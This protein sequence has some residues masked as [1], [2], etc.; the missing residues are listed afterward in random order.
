MMLS[1][2]IILLVCLA[3]VALLFAVAWFAD[4][5]SKSGRA[6]IFQ[7][8]LIY[9]LSISVYC[10]SWTF[11]GAVGSAARNGLEF[12][13]IYLGPTIVFIGFWFLLRKLVRIGRVHRIT[14]IADLISSRYGKGESLAVLV[15][16]IAVI[17]TTPYIALQLKAL[18]TSLQVITNAGA[19]NPITG[20]LD[21]P[22][23]STAFWIAA[24]MA[25]FTIM[26]G[27]R[28]IDSNE[29]HHGV[30]AAIAIEALVKLFALL[31]VGL[32]V[33]FYLADGPAEVFEWAPPDLLKTEEVF[34][35]RWVAVTFLAAVAII[36]LPR[37]FQVTVVENSDERHIF[38]ASWMFPLYL[39]LISLFVLPIAI[40]GLTFLPEGADPD[41]FVLT[42]PLAQDQSFLALIAFL[43]G[44]SSATSMVIVAC[45]ALS[46]MVSNH[47]V[48]PL[49]LR[50]PIIEM[51]ASG[52]VRRLLL[53]S[54]RAS[55]C[56]ILLLGF[57]Y[58]QV[59]SKSDALAAFGL[60]A[61]AGVAQFLPSIIGGLYWAQATAKG[62]FAGLLAGFT[63]WL[64]TL[65]L[66]SFE[67]AIF[68]TP[69][70]IANGPW[71][72]AALRP[73]ALFGLTGLDPLV[74]A[75]FW[76]LSINT[77]IFI[78]ASLL[79]DP[80]P[81]E[82]LQAALFI[83]VFKTPAGNASR[84]LRR[85]AASNDLFIIA[86]R[87]LGSEPAYRL[88]S[89]FARSQGVEGHLPRADAEF[90]G[91]LER[92]LAG[93]VGASTA[94]AMISQVVTG[95]TISLD[96]L[97]HIVD[98]AQQVIDYSRQLE[99]QSTELQETARKLREA[100]E[101][102]RQLDVQKDDFL[103]QVSHELRTPMTS[104]RS[105]AQILQETPDIDTKEKQRFAG[106]ILD[107]SVRLTRLLDDIL[108]LARLEGQ[109]VPFT[110]L[111]SEADATLAHAVATCQGLAA[112]DGVSLTAEHRVADIVI[113]VDTDRLKQVYLNVITNAIKYNSSK[114]PTVTVRSRVE[115]DRYHVYIEDN[116]PGIRADDRE[117]IFQKFSRGWRDTYDAR[118]GTGLGLAISWQIMQ[119]MRGDLTLMPQKP[120]QG[121][122][123]R[124]SLP[125]RR[126]QES[127][128]DAAAE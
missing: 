25:V 59:S 91:H 15:T 52:D 39:L 75:L 40:G 6:S 7:S 16:L 99:S 54:R 28:T 2:N 47:I 125:Y 4:K 41:M 29:R 73:E 79:F 76:S 18:T 83:D 106:I 64:Y 50:L 58:F 9:T 31:A 124:I 26:F 94:R 105:F 69:E 23:A 12:I 86:Q 98:E 116:G 122:C 109:H 45:I 80:K 120:G 88:F 115:R 24:G 90:I 46:T 87:I 93:S 8:P 82:R 89:S 121:A 14:S 19:G 126:R 66:P 63:L 30:V 34:G 33:M 27:T 20:A 11:Y 72:I 108:D 35:P 123:F 53:I 95:E 62:A 97:M 51:R 48:M 42:L 10:T 118:S 13:T 57:V 84:F 85:Q 21:D 77:L 100:N 17:G 43:G 71:G 117:R 38:T 92:E 113:D 56:V 110:L 112:R 49:A 74:H 36:C 128:A 103:S 107:E 127:D 96:S 81:L 65:F 60:I 68:M 111:E 3:Y 5:Q 104:I 119:H 44:F 61:F 67:G 32:F 22:G 55:I 70:V 37:Q 101:R 78:G 114:E 1:N 102:L